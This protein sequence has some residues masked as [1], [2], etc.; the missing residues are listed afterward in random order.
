MR[1]SH[2]LFSSSLLIASAALYPAQSASAQ[3]MV[4]GNSEARICYE[5]A[6]YGRN[7]TRTNIAS[8]ENALSNELLSR[9]DKASTYVNLGVLQMRS[10]NYTKAQASY[11]EAL[12]LGPEISEVYINQGANMIYLRD[13]AS[14][15]TSL[16][17]A[18]ALKTNKMPEA[19]YNRSEVY[20][21]MKRYKEAYYDLKEALELRPD[22]QPALK[23]IGKYEVTTAS[24]TKS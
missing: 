16:D 1:I 10:G 17:K 18:I 8:C 4:I 3:A 24:R 2:I 14:A 12:E 22:W 7:G 11:A 9:K 23:A 21:E 15:L 5:N 6:K 13:Y 20:Y 19:L